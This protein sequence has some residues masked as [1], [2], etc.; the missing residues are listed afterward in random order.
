[1]ADIYKIITFNVGS[2]S[3][4][5]G[6]ISILNIEKPHIVMLQEVTLTSEQL[7]LHVSKYGY[8]AETNIDINNQTALGTGFVWKSNLPVSDVS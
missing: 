2:S 4:L 3:T 6:L 8:S 7:T 5:G 1:M